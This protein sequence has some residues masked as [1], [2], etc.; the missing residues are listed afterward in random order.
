M[1]T[2]SFYNIK[3]GVAKTTSTLA[4]T[5]ILLTITVSVCLYLILTSRRTQPKHSAVMMQTVFPLLIYLYLKN[6]VRDVIKHSEYGIDVIPANYNTTS[7]QIRMYCTMLSVLN[8]HDSRLSLR[9]FRIVMI[10]V[11][12]IILLKIIWQ[13]STVLLLLT[14]CLYQ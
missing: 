7:R 11:L 12:L 5:Q 1:K 3:G 13:L 9:K 8:K 6:I 14:M 2:I 4:F 10:I